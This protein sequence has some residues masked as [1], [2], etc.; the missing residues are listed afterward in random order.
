MN[1]NDFAREITLKEG[2][3]QSVS[4]AQMREILKIIFTKNSLEKI[5]KVYFKYNK[6]AY[7]KT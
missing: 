1:L 4:I 3:K 7:E 6:N 5:I 2:L